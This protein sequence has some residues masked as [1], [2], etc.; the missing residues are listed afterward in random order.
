[1]PRLL[2]RCVEDLDGLADWPRETAESYR[3]TAAAALVR[4]NRE[5]EAT[6]IGIADPTMT[7]A[8]AELDCA[9]V[10]SGITDATVTLRKLGG[11]PTLI[12]QTGEPASMMVATATREPV[13]FVLRTDETVVEVKDGDWTEATLVVAAACAPAEPSMAL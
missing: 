4:A 6:I 13:G 9:L 5:L 11:K 12:V 3:P 2:S 10:D 8:R 1:M 7:V